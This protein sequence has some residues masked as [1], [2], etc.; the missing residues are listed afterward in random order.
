MR[1]AESSPQ[2]PAWLQVVGP[3]ILNIELNI[4][5]IPG[6]H[7]VYR[8]TQKSD[9]MKRPQ[10]HNKSS[11]HPDPGSMYVPAAL[12]G[13]LSTALPKNLLFVSVDQASSGLKALPFTYGSFKVK[14][15]TRT[16]LQYL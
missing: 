5:A 7:S 12:T 16:S 14:S 8:Q 2:P 6:I 15:D 11:S 9:Q 3:S 4:K 13:I 1:S 10:R